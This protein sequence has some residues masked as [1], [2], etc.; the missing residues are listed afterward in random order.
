M[1]L[2][3]ETFCWI[4]MK[5]VRCSV[6][7]ESIRTFYEYII[8]LSR[9]KNIQKPHFTSLSHC[10][11]LPRMTSAIKL[12]NIGTLS[13]V[14]PKRS[15]RYNRNG[16]VSGLPIDDTFAIF[17]GTILFRDRTSSWQQQCDST[18]SCWRSSWQIACPLHCLFQKFVS[19]LFFSLFPCIDVFFSTLR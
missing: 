10:L 15:W 11:N 7:C 17:D 6:D 19:I 14:I 16:N 8:P 4:L 5:P 12:T 2:K 9:F 1:I 18:N 3:F 13:C